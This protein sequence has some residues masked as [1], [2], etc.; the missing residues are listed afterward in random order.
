M[1]L[2]NELGVF[3]DK[4]VKGALVHV[5]RDH[6]NRSVDF[7]DSKKVNNVRVIHLPDSNKIKKKK[8]EIETKI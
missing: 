6:V 4:F 1:R 7:A 3:G 2:S 8:K 5:F